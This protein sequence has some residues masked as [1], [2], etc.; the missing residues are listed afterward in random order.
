MANLFDFFR[1]KR[2]KVERVDE[3]ELKKNQPSA[4]H[5][6]SADGQEFP[7]RPVGASPLSYNEY[8]KKTKMYEDQLNE[9]QFGQM[10]K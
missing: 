9:K 5:G 3:K 1:K 8:M 10:D 6:V 4:K 2:K 7:H